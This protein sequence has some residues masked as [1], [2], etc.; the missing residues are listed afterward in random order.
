M[1]SHSMSGEYH[2]QVP[3]CKRWFDTPLGLHSHEA[4]VHTG[5]GNGRIKKIITVSLSPSLVAV[6]DAREDFSSRS[7]FIEH[8]VRAYIEFME[9]RP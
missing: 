6:I 1:A 3:G 4:R 2:C 5:H 7:A 9:A 8:A